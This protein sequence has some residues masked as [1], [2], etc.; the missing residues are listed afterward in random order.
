MAGVIRSPKDFWAG[1]LYAGFGAAAVLI[2]RDYGLGSSSRMGPGYFPTVLGSLLLLIGLASLV[3][4]FFAAGEPIGAI[5]WKGL[6]LVTLA[7]VLFGALLR[8]AGLVIALAAV[9]LVS[10]AASVKFR[11]DGRALA[12]MGGLIVFCGLV[13]VKGLGLPVSLLGTW[14]T[15]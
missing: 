13:F 9:I 8:P 3:R 10:A 2:A 1:V 4:S 12:L 7:T 15:A 14:F 11:F 6:L 5:A